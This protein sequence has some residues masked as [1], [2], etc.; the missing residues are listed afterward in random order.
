MNRLS[1]GFAAWRNPF[2]GQCHL[3]S[4]RRPDV[5]CLAFWSKNFR[6]FLP[7]LAEIRRLG[8]PCFFN[9]TINALPP[10]LEGNVVPADDAVD[11]L[12]ELAD[13]FSPEQITWRYDPIVLSGVTP[14]AY[15]EARFAELAARL[16]GRAGRVY[17]S[18]VAR[19]ARVERNFAEFERL[20]GLRIED[21]PLPERQRLA[22]R[23]AALADTHGMPLHVCC[24]DA[25]VGGPVYKGRCLDGGIM[26][27]LAGGAWRGKARP[28]R[29]GCG[30]VASVDIGCYDSCPHG[31]VYCYA[32]VN[33]RRAAAV[34][35]AHDPASVILGCSRAV[36]ERLVA[37]VRARTAAAAACDDRRGLT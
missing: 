32:N 13:R 6:P 35:A 17:I 23:L 18:F 12:A 37:A 10:A 15:H 36:A 19:Y 28:T 8:Y 2:G 33:K 16:H 34:H 21:P 29:P 30:C 31:C 5:V 7:A 27:R 14:P 11:S 26:A 24:N 22:R 20:H 9:Y 1:E 3:V 25:L 4:L